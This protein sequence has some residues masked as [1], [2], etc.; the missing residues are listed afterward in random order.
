MTE[1]ATRRIPQLDM[2]VAELLEHWPLCANVLNARR[3]AC[4][5]CELSAFETLAG[6]ARVYRVQES[7]L[8]A[9]LRAAANQSA[10]DR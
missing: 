5:G 10:E 7:E 4:V 3:M 8:L 1:D 6:A 9:A 2:S